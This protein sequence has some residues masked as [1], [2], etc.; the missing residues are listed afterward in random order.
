MNLDFRMKYEPHFLS[1]GLVH[2]LHS[3]IMLW[4]AVA[5]IHV[6]DKKKIMCGAL[7]NTNDKEHLK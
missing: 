6:W 3:K 7:L 1:L 4:M 2:I 5:K